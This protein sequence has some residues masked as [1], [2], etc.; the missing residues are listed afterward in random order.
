MGG[1]SFRKDQL[2]ADPLIPAGD[3]SDTINPTISGTILFSPD[4]A[5]TRSIGAPAF[6]GQEVV[7][8][9]ADSTNSVALTWYDADGNAVELK[10]GAA[11]TTLDSA[12]DVI[13]AHGVQIGGVLS[14]KGIGVYT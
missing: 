5:E 14:W 11:T 3:D 9:L 4:G 6:L 10:V 13:I 8:A 1:P 12:E 2:Y 7:C